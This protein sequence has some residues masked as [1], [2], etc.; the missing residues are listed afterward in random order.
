VNQ[1][2]E[3]PK[4]Q[5]QKQPEQEAADAANFSAYT[6]LKRP[7]KNVIKKEYIC[8]YERVHKH[9]CLTKKEAS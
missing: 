5:R 6:E 1:Q 3:H 4:R 7:E 2:P 8:I 9:I